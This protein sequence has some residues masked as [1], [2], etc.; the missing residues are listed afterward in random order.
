MVRSAGCPVPEVFPVADA[1][2][3]NMDVL[4]RGYFEQRIANDEV[5]EGQRR[6]YCPLC[7]EQWPGS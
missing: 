3:A 4:F 2:L 1:V 5:R 7:G 6:G